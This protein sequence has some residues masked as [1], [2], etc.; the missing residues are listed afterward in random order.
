MLHIMYIIMYI[1]LY[2][3]KDITMFRRQV[4]KKLLDFV[5]S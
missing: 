2:I 1:D 4:L 5:I 3:Q